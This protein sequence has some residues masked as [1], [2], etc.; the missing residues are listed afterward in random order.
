MTIS[1][2]NALKSVIADEHWIKKTL[3][4]GLISLVVLIGTGMMEAKGISAA[5]RITGIA[6]YLI[7]GSFLLGFVISTV[8]K[9]LNN[10]LIGWSEW[11]EPNIMQKGLKFIFSYIVYTIVITILFA[12]L[13]VAFTIIFG[14]VI[15]LIGYLINLAL[16]L[17]TQFAGAL[18]GL[19]FTVVFIIILLYF[20]Q[21]ISAALVSYYKNQKFHDLMALKK[22]YRMIKENQ[23]AAWT[24]VGKTILFTLLFALIFIVAC[25]TIIGVIAIPFIYFVSRMALIDL[26]NQYGKEI[27]V[28]KYLA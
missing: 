17:P 26:Y 1:L 27:D 4:G 18:L 3:I 25:I 10:G 14:L 15:G 24:L 7:F 19:L 20:M 23:H 6:L 2:G 28:D 22:H 5:V 13:V 11:S 12:C 8:N 21:F 9:K 16:H